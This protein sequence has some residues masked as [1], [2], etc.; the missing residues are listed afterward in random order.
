MS[1][2][3]G[4]YKIPFNG[5]HMMEYT[6]YAEGIVSLGA[7]GSPTEWR[8]NGEFEAHVLL[9]GTHRGR[10]AARIT[11][12]NTDNGETY[13]MGMEAFYEAITNFGVSPGGHI[14]GKWTFRKQGSNYGLFPV[15]DKK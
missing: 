12:R 11:C 13:S 7:W 5:R 2:K 9:T 14:E 10:S 3:T 8:E 1:K 15:I 4:Q 6:G